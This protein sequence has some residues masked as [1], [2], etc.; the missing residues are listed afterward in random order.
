MTT[1]NSE[2]YLSQAIDSILI[3]S[4]EDF[5]FIIAD[6]WSSDNTFQI[7]KKYESLDKRIKILFDPKRKSIVDC[8]NYCMENVNG[9]LIAIMESDDISTVD[10]FKYQVD[11][12][13]KNSEIW[14]I[15]SSANIINGSGD[16]I[17]TID[18]YIDHVSIYNNILLFNPFLNPSVMFRASILR[19]IW[20]Y[21]KEFDVIQD[22]EYWMRIILSWIKWENL[23]QR[24]LN[25]RM[26]ENNTSKI[27]WLYIKNRCKLLREKYSTKYGIRLTFRQKS[28]LWLD[29]SYF[30]GNYFWIIPILKNIWCLKY[31][32][33]CRE[34][35]L[36]KRSS[37]GWHE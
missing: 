32:S 36:D 9:T 4:Y 28:L 26:H 30:Y 3:Q 15:G 1:Y 27:K 14:F 7:L 33:Q 21:D 20:F 31:L 2:K 35:L 23:R 25:Y 22:Y 29:N 19:Q 12:L 13:N 6:W 18:P 16:I 8:M 34:K 24:L 10:R 5:E 37:H 11:F 17:W